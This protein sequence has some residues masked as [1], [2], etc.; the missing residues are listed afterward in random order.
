LSSYIT[1][2]GR[3]I[4]DGLLLWRGRFSI[5]QLW[6]ISEDE[7][8]VDGRREN[9]EAELKKEIW[10]KVKFQYELVQSKM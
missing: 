1:G 3:L 7:K 10:T 5:V 2:S 9:A 6:Q 8:R 4:G